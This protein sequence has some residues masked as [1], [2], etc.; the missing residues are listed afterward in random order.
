MSLR[1]HS[2]RP[3]PWRGP[4]KDT[5]IFR[6]LN[7]LLIIR[8]MA[9]L[10]LTI[11]FDNK[12]LRTKSAPVKKIDRKIKQLVKDMTDTMMDCDGLGIA[13]SQ[14]GVNLRIYIARLNFDTPHE[15]LV[16]MLNTEFLS[17]SE[18]TVDVEEGCLSL[19]KRFGI[20][21]RSAEVTIKYM[22]VKGKDHTL[23]FT[24]LNARIMQHET[25]HLNG[26]LIADKMIREIDVEAL[27]K[28]RKKSDT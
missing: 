15:M 22:D 3:P 21:R 1:A 20:V 14:V 2:L 19:P 23:H 25:D 13:A 9:L 10:P 26:I 18:E 17:M 6:N 16:P 12:I 4:R 11:G 8:S 27:R 24:G 28:A 7:L 5:F